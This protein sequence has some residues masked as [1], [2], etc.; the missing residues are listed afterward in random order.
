MLS[1]NAR[2]GVEVGV[3]FQMGKA[4]GAPSARVENQLG[5]AASL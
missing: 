5:I 4:G 3:M 2:V 1:K